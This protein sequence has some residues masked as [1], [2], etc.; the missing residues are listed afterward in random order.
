M[1]P[2]ILGFFNCGDK[3]REENQA[4]TLRK[5][6]GFPAGYQGGG[7][8][9]VLVASHTPPGARWEKCWDPPC[10]VRHEQEVGIRGEKRVPQKTCY[11]GTAFN[12]K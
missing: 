5:G 12:P 6:W 4:E 3:G 9:P 1:G 2:I 8:T 11:S 7:R 10:Q